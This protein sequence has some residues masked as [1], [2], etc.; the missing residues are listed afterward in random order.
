MSRFVETIYQIANSLSL[1][2]VDSYVDWHPISFVKTGSILSQPKH[3]VN[4]VATPL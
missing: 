3:P 2:I 4:F 1:D